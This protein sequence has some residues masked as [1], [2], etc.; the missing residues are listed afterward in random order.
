MN[1]AFI[2]AEVFPYSKTGGLA[3]I[4]HFLP[5]A[6]AQKEFNVTVITP[7]YQT[8]GKYHDQMTFLGR[9]TIKMGGIETD[10]NY[11]VLKEANVD[12]VF[13]Q[14]MHYFERD[15]FYGYN[16][17]AERF[18]CF[19]YAVLE[20]LPL[21][22]Y[23]PQ[24][25]H[26]NDWQTGMI[27]YLLD[28][29]YRWKE[30]Y[31]YLHTLLTI[32]NLEYQGNFDTYVSR[33]FNTDFNYAYMHFNRVNFLKAGIERAA[34]INTVSPTYKEEILTSEYGFS[35]DGS[36]WLR[37]DALSG[38]L[39]GIDDQ[40]FNPSTDNTLIQNYQ[41]SNHVSGKRANKQ[42]L[43]Q[44]F[45]LG[46]NLDI[47]LVV[48]VGRYANQ[49][50]LWMIRETLEDV[51]NYS[52]AKF[53]FLG[54]GD[55]SYGHHFQYMT[56]K[57]PDRVGNYVGY[58]ESLAH[59]LY[60]AADIFLMPSE[61]EP[62]GLGQMIAMKYGTLPLVRETGGLKDTVIPYNQYTHEGT[63]FSFSNPVSFEFKE[64]LFE[65]ISLFNEEPKVWKKLIKQAMEKDYSN[66]KMAQEYIQLYQDI[67][68]RK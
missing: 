38:I 20:V 36:L 63:G 33:F 67:I 48:Y 34:A 31:Q 50:G 64:K 51:I 4:A 54:S 1:I 21:L 35:L 45:N 39:N 53:F 26:L 19:S 17:D 3:D 5:K 60:A 28:M 2:T 61:F 12:I 27:P 62:C 56:D 15:R 68:G 16:D 47:P 11:F 66:D 40:T 37:K 59:L 49:K 9:K 6:L 52:N 13:V 7:Y 8:I 42:A 10:V 22:N 65:A 25:L 46:D 58:N 29:H 41:Y 32:H 57:Y 30:P 14:N 23:F 24:I 43:Y 55:P 44:Q 18:S